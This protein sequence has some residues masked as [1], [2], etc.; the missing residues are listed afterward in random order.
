MQCLSGHMR[1]RRKKKRVKRVWD[2]ALYGSFG[3]VANWNA[4]DI[5]V[6]CSC[7][8]LSH[9]FFCGFSIDSR[10][11]DSTL[12]R[13][14]VEASSITLTA[15]LH[16]LFYVELTI[17]LNTITW[18]TVSDRVLATQILKEASFFLSSVVFQFW[19]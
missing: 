7:S 15:L 1:Q 4:E 17:T 19:F 9:R 12:H 5:C 6:H 13:L 11:S 14:L 16:R 2:E 18:S 8:I 10:H 3:G